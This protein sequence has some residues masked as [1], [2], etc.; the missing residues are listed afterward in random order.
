LRCRQPECRRLQIIILHM[1][2][3]LRL[4]WMTSTLIIV[5]LI[6]A[7][8]AMRFAIHGREVTVPEMRGK[9]PAEARRLAEAR[10]LDA[11]VEREYYSP[12]VPES[13]VLSQMPAAGTVVRRGWQ[14]RLALSLGPQ[15]VAIPQ[16]VGDSLRA[17]QITIAQRG[18]DL[19]SK[20]N[21]EFPSATAGQ[22]MAQ[23]PPPN[24]SDVAAPKVSLLVA[25]APTPRSYV[26][27]SFVG[28]PLG[29]ITQALKDAGFS[30]GKVTVAE[31]PV[32]PASDVSSSSPASQAGPATSA[33]STPV[34]SPSA[35]SIIVSQDPAA[36]AKVSAATGINFVVR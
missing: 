31:A 2:G 4:L 32:M 6:S 26:M 11:G 3:V 10:G 20:A 36:G 30:V 9:A 28:R 24:A 17:A 1:R 16:V 35:A 23:D 22:V 13:K 21:I 25:E 12:T 27:P 5:A 18:L 14:V 15:R 8:T 33:P 7:L 34:S 19:A 29:S